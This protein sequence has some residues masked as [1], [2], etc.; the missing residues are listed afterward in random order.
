MIL[1]IGSKREQSRFFIA[2]LLA[3]EPTVQAVIG[4]GLVAS[5]RIRASTLLYSV[6]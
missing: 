4:N 5:D 2:L 3:S 6:W 1:A